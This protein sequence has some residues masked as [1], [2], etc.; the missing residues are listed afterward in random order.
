M[1]WRRRRKVRPEPGPEMMARFEAR[2]AWCGPVG[3]EADGLKLHVGREQSLFE[4]VCPACGR[5]NLRPLAV[6]EAA[7]LLAAGIHQTRGLAP[8][9]LLEARQGPPIGWD[10]VL[11]FH[12]ELDRLN[13]TL[14]DASNRRADG[15]AMERNA[16]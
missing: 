13:R 6:R 16:A 3:F 5:L 15:P 14:I 1:F 8:F 2:C 4:F 9:E 7:T 10:D 11:E 12:E